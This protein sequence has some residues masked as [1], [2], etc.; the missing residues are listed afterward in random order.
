MNQLHDTL[1]YNLPTFSIILET[2]NLSTSELEGFYRSVTSLSEQNP[3]A[4]CANEVLIIDSGDTPPQILEQI[5]E[6]YPWIAI[7]RSPSG[8][9]YYEAKMEGARLVT[10]EIVLLCDS[11]CVYAPGW[12]TQIL[13]PFTTSPDVQIVGGDTATRSVGAYGLAM[14]F[15][16]LF[17]GFSA[18]QQPYRSSAYYCNNIAFRRNFLLQH[19]IPTQLPLYRGNCYIHATSL[20]RQG[21]EIW[22]QPQAKATHAP[23]NGLSHFFWRFLLIGRD[24]LFMQRLVTQ[25][26]TSPPKNSHQDVTKPRLITQIGNLFPILRRVKTVDIRKLIY[27]PLAIP[28]MLAA[29]FLEWCGQLITYVHPNYLLRVYS[30]MEGTVYEDVTEVV[31]RQLS[32]HDRQ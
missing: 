32:V 17:N 25:I 8:I 27:L 2:E 29:W 23:P 30:A 10:G 21:Y 1:E 6:R 13:I 19:P 14:H 24:S 20:I 9:S 4:Q 31:V 7:H 5:R 16:Y 12:L 22:R 26:N 15:V 11:D 3:S 18:K 28:I